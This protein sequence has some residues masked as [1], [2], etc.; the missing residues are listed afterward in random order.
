MYLLSEPPRS[1]YDLEFSIFGFPVR[2]TWTHWLMGLV[3]GFGLVQWIEVLYL[4][5][6]PARVV[7]LPGCVG[8]VFL[9]I[10]V[11]EL[12]HAFAFRQF[13]IGSSVV[14]YH[15]GGLAIPHGGLHLGFSVGRPKPL[16]DAW[17]AA[18]G[19][20]AQLALAAVVAVVAIATGD[21]A[22]WIDHLVWLVV[23]GQPLVL[24]EGAV[25]A[26]VAFVD[27]IVWPSVVWGLLN[28][29]L[30][31]WPLD[32]GRIV[33][34]FIVLFGG[35]RRFGHVVSVVAAAGIVLWGMATQ[36]IFLIVLFGSLAFN[37]YQ[38]LQSHF[39]SW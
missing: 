7:L 1:P 2:V 13:G 31:I 10:L 26:F 15:F 5:A 14:L 29:V 4:E 3:F 8:A 28:L 11:H 37:N 16:Q 25:P 19:P 30:P 24:P 34:E 18:A 23:P 27:F 36:D 12:G 20:F 32:G 9:S 39:G 35:T 22:S 38:M 21:P 33:H 17:I 6:A